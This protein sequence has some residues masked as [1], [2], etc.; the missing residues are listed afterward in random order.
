MNIERI[1]HK[2]IRLV[3]EKIRKRTTSKSELIHFWTTN[4]MW[5]EMHVKI[6]L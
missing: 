5:L 4:F 2:W 1:R 6:S 3:E